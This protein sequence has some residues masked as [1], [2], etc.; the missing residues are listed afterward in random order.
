MMAV[1]AL[2][3]MLLAASIASA[4]SPRKEGRY[5]GKT[6]QGARVSVKIDR[7][8][9]IEF[10]SAEVTLPCPRLGPMRSSGGE[11]DVGVRRNGSFSRTYTA[12]ILDEGG[13]VVDGRRQLLLEVAKN[14]IS[15]R[16][17][18]A[19]KVAGTWRV[20]SAFYFYDPFPDNS[21]PIDKCDSGVV[22]WTA[23]LRR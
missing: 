4:A 23:R 1:P 13:F 16:F 22:T 20:R 6:S 3:I 21:D 11:F 12:A 9:N 7:E 17:N 2:A 10:L 19:R 18:T 15:G 5:V 8:R 14:E